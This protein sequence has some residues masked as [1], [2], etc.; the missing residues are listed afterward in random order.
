MEYIQK[1]ITKAG[2]KLNK[3]FNGLKEGLLGLESKKAQQGG[4][5]KPRNKKAN[6][7]KTKKETP[8][9]ATKANPKKTKKETPRKATKANPKKTKKETPRKATKGTPKKAKKPTHK[10]TSNPKKT[11]KETPRKATKANPKKTKKETPRKATKGTP[12]KTK[13]ETLG[14]ATKAAEKSKPLSE[15]LLLTELKRRCQE[16]GVTQSG[17]KQEL[18]ERLSE[19]AE[20]SKPLSEELSKK[21]LKRR[22]Q[23]AGVTQSGTK[24]ELVERLSEAA[25][26]SK[27]LDKLSDK[28]LKRRCKE[29][30]VAHTG[31]RQKTIERLETKGGAGDKR[32]AVVPEGA[33]KRP[34][35]D[36]GDSSKSAGKRPASASD[37]G[38]KCKL[39]PGQQQI[40]DDLVKQFQQNNH[41]K[42]LLEEENALLH[43]ELERKDSLL[44]EAQKRVEQLQDGSG[45]NGKVAH[46]LRQRQGIAKISGYMKKEKYQNKLVQLGLICL[47]PG[48]PSEGQHVFHIIANTNG[49]PD[50]TDNYLFALGGTFNMTISN[51]FDHLNCYLAGKEKARR[52]VEICEATARDSSKHK[53]IEKRTK[54]KDPVLY[55]NS[56]HKLKSGETLFG[57]GQS[58][59]TR[60]ILS[61]GRADRNKTT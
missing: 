39:T 50:H 7:K 19:A 53:W 30:R 55:T 11:K 36:D 20:K 26:K 18:V 16:A 14:K 45:I 59:F 54:N 42:E 43:Q 25:E 38:A 27:P 5:P 31:N 22:C 35:H 57:E 34:K 33:V 41:E 9:K 17:T 23:E 61:Q 49:G 29:A 2:K 60:S 51:R 4:A 15:E 47:Q 13:K 52:A 10:P 44:S 28:G 21:E 56:I 46:T 6:P 37:E 8:R 12:K 40:V 58:L 48:A 24:Q 3:K 32:R 1:I